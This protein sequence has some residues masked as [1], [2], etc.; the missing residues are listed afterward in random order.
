MMNLLQILSWQWEKKNFQPKTDL[1]QTASD[2][3][4]WVDSL[5]PKKLKARHGFGP[6]KYYPFQ[7]YSFSFS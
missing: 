7:A 1:F 5:Q 6:F 3:G 2:P 4:E